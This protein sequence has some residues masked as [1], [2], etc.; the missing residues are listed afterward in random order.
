ML[1]LYLMTQLDK[2]PN[3]YS[4]LNLCLLKIEFTSVTTTIAVAPIDTK[5]KKDTIKHTGF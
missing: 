2:L 3:L 5:Y 1:K 4:D